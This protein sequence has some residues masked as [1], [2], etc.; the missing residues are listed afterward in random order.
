MSINCLHRGKVLSEST[1]I[2][3]IHGKCSLEYLHDRI[4]PCSTCVD[5]R[6]GQQGFQ[7]QQSLMFGDMVETALNGIGITKERISSWLGVE[8]NCEE[9]KQK[10]NTLHNWARWVIAGKTDK[11]KEYLEEIL[12]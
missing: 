3:E 11:A 5:R 6:E 10:L 2:C 1:F 7:N 8:C 9:R 4:R 12:S